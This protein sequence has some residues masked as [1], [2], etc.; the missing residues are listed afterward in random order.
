[1]FIMIPAKDLE[2]TIARPSGVTEASI[3]EQIHGAAFNHMRY[4]FMDKNMLS[5]D[6]INLLKENGYSVIIGYGD[7]ARVKISW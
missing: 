7:V 4:T 2:R 6:M 3:M 1:M 5:N